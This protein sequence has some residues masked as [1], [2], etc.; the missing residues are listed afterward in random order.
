MRVASFDVVR[1]QC[2]FRDERVEVRRSEASHVVVGLPDSIR[3]LE[4]VAVRSSASSK[5]KFE[6]ERGERQ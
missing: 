3:A 1:T 2:A 4:Q 6:L 5:E